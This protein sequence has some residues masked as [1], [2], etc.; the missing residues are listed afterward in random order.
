MHNKPII[1]STR[2][3]KNVKIMYDKKTLHK[4]VVELGTKITKDYNNKELYVVGVLKGSFIFYADLVREIDLPVKCDFIQLSSYNGLK[5]SSGLV[6]MKKDLQYDIENKHVLIVED[7][8]DTACTMHWLLHT[9]G[10]RFPASL[11]VC[12]L[13]EK[14][15]KAKVHLP[16]DY[17]GFKIKNEFVVGY[18]LDFDEKY[19]NLSYI[20]TYIDNL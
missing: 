10:K 20:G 5:N 3:D 4:R 12:T 1:A 13:L 18:G 17:I 19:R 11:K 14:P 16:I 7:I 2:W 9:L 15:E 6:S 8:I